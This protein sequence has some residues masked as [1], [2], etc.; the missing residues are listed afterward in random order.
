MKE[1]G[2][3]ASPSWAVLVRTAVVGTQREPAPAIAVGD[4]ELD[5][6]IA[7]R[8]D[9]AAAEDAVLRAAAVAGLARRAGARA[10]DL[11]NV[12]LTPAPDETLPR[13][14]PDAANDLGALLGGGSRET[15][16]LSEWLAVAA[17]ARVRVP[18][19]R[20]P[21]L[22]ALGTHR[23]DLRPALVKVIGARGGWL[24]A[25]EPEWAFALGADDPQRAWH[26]G[27]R[28]A[29]VLALAAL[30]ARDAA[31]ARELLAAAWQREPPA[32]RAVFV[33]ALRTGLSAADEPFLE[34]VLDDRRKDVRGA[35]AA[36]LARLRDS[37]LVQRAIARGGALVTVKRTKL[38]ARAL[39]VAL[40]AECTP[41]MERDGIEPRPP[42]GT[43]ERAWWLQQMVAHVPPSH[44]TSAYG[45]GAGAMI[46]LARKTDVEQPL[47]YGL[48]IA[49]ARYD[50]DAWR[51]AWIEA[52][53]DVP[54]LMPFAL[55]ANTG[56]AVA[57]PE[58]I[59]V[60]VRAL[61]AND[62][63]AGQLAMVVPGP[64][65]VTFS[66]AFVQYVQ[67]QLAVGASPAAWAL[68]RGLLTVGAAQVAPETPGMLE[69]W[70]EN[71]A[72][73]AVRDAIATFCE[74]VALRA[75]MRAH[76]KATG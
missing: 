57:R 70:P 35:A 49:T 21:Q 62:P 53:R 16:L 61:D 19:E 64:W 54:D 67:D 76:L 44:W 15:M 26:D 34:T 39:S 28:A 37:R 3:A 33:D 11:A 38:G 6:L 60:I 42:A 66:R 18:E 58:R 69:G 41:A 23:R 71:M 40:P 52:A 5:A 43:G 8:G 12:V 25:Q 65:D 9:T 75:A 32:E 50:D 51:I 68:Q 10:L 4:A 30:R 13:C 27:D 24:A 31:H 55:T 29:R 73:Q 2:R 36:L 14:S 48:A 17:Q 1:T 63:E 72:Q 47:L 46:A 59:A 7:A 22:L 45:I 74:T 56:A 20:L